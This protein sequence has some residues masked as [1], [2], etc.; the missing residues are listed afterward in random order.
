MQTYYCP[1]IETGQL[2]SLDEGESQHISKVMR[3]KLGDELELCNGSGK[4]FSAEIVGI[5]KKNVEVVVGQCVEALSENTDG[6][7][8]AIAP[9]KNISRFEWFLEK[10]TE[11]GVGE[12]TPFVSENSERKHIKSERLEKII[13]SAMKQSKHLY[14]PVLNELCEF[15]SFLKLCQSQQKFIAYCEDLPDVQLIKSIDSDKSICVVIGPEGDFTPDEIFLAE[16]LGF[17]SVALGNSRLRTE[18]AGIVVAQMVQDVKIIKGG[19]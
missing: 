2:V 8:I 12:I 15:E 18:T 10:A 13:V 6:L 19:L 5:S 4:R 17:K 14:K 1:S 16:R 3:M 7:H 9:T 11:I